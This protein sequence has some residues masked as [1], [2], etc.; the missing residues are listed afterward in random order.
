MIV[1][2][3]RDAQREHAAEKKRAAELRKKGKQARPNYN[4]MSNV[5]YILVRR[6]YWYSD[7]EHDHSL[8]D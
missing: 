3:R 1:Q 7:A 2:E 5:D 8:L 6:K 4:D